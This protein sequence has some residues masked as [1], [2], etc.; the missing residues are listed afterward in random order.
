MDIFPAY[1]QG[2][3]ANGWGKDRG[4]IYH[5]V[6]AADISSF[7]KA[8]CGAYPQGRSGGWGTPIG[9]AAVTCKRCLKKIDAH[10]G[11]S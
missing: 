3:N 6:R 11:G 8:L 5:A 1:K 10:N 7:G 2:R 9:A 4:A